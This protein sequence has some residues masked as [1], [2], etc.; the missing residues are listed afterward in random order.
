MVLTIA[1]DKSLEFYKL[2]ID[3]KMVTLPY[4]SD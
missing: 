3:G 4:R 1:I 2:K